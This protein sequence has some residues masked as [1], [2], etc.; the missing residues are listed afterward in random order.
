MYI[1][2]QISG[3]NAFSWSLYNEQSE[4]VGKIRL[5]APWQ[6]DNILTSPVSIHMYYSYKNL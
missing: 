6:S 4:N 3:L 5:A 1:Y 2:R